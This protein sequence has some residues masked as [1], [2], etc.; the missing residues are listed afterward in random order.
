[1]IEFNTAFVTAFVSRRM[2]VYD[3]RLCVIDINDFGQARK[4]AL[5]VVDNNTN[6]AHRVGYSPDQ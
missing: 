3:I 1:M 6:V 2:L 4:K 5:N